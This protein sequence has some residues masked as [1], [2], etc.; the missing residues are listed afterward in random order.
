M[1]PEAAPRVF[2]TPDAYM[3]ARGDGITGFR[4][5]PQA[6]DQIGEIAAKLDARFAL[7]VAA[8]GLAIVIRNG[9]R[10][11]PKW[12]VRFVDAEPDQLYIPAPELEAQLPWRPDLVSKHGIAATGRPVLELGLHGFSNPFGPLM[13]AKLVGA[14]YDPNQAMADARTMV[15]LDRS[16]WFNARRVGVV[17]TVIKRGL[18]PFIVRRGPVTDVVPA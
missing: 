17:H 5:N 15:S 3:V 1:P 14:S 10:P 12:D 7:P 4:P 9:N 11:I 6:I 2:F 18:E 16:P 8:G 13:A